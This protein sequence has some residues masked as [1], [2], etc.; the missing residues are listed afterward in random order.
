MLVSADEGA[1][2]RDFLRLQAAL[3]HADQVNKA[4]NE[5]NAF[6]LLS[7]VNRASLR[8]VRDL[9]APETLYPV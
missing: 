8:K 7:R 2:K 9:A 3:C 5:L 1:I 6:V 4:M